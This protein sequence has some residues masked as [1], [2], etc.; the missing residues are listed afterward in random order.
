MA[1]H[2]G[3]GAAGVHRGE[4][5][6]HLWWGNI[7]NTCLWCTC[8]SKHGIYGPYSHIWSQMRKTTTQCVSF[9]H[10]LYYEAVRLRVVKAP[11]ILVP[12]SM[13]TADEVKSYFCHQ[14]LSN[15]KG[16][17]LHHDNYLNTPAA[18]RQLLVGD[19]PCGPP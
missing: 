9:I 18:H 14:C 13:A 8:I 17:N 3:H 11:T 12:I 6:A 7:I 19:V 2:S 15:K 5:L 16:K 1:V 10:T 4:C